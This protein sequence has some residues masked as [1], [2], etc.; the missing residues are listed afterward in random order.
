MFSKES[1]FV[2][3]FKRLQ[4]PVVVA[5]YLTFNRAQGQSLD[6]CGLLLPQSVFSHGHLYVGLSRCGD[7]NNVFIY[8]NQDE[9]E[10]LQHDLPNDAAF[11][12]NIVYSEVFN[13]E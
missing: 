6:R 7:P 12:R 4:F 2:A 5:Y 10:G 13:Q 1:D 9:F 3:I 11:T 8:A